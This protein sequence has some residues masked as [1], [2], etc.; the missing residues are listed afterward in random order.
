MGIVSS[1]INDGEGRYGSRTRVNRLVYE[2]TNS[3]LIG[4]TT[5]T[6]D[7][8]LNGK[9]HNIYVDATRSVL[10]LPGGG[11]VAEG[12]F[13][14]LHADLIDGAGTPAPYPYHAPISALDFTAASPAPYHF[15]TS[16]GAATADGTHNDGNHLVVF[17]GKQSGA[18]AL[19]K[20]YNGAGAAVV[21]DDT[22]PWTGLVCGK[23]RISLTAATSWDPT[24][25]SIFVVILYD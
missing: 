12:G 25:G 5:A 17:S 22:V 4:L 24:T 10:L 20:T 15:Q 8:D 6:A 7:V 21:M 18:A 9:I 11:G 1:S 16:E 19:P 23:V 2:F 13:Q 14:L 3:D